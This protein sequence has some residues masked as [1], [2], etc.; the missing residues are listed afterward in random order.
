MVYQAYMRVGKDGVR[1]R[2]K[3]GKIDIIHYKVKYGTQI[4]S[5]SSRQQFVGGGR[6][7]L[8]LLQIKGLAYEET[9]R[10][11][12]RWTQN[13][14]GTKIRPVWEKKNERQ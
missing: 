8:R 7:N 9:E 6:G 12:G 2:G 11:H 3:V 10:M 1:V 14:Q 4:W 5:M 13:I